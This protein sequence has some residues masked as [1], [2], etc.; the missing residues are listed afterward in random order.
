MRAIQSED[1]GRLLLA[2]AWV[3]AALLFCPSPCFAQGR[4]QRA[5]ATGSLSGTVLGA[6]E[7]PVSGARV[8]VQTSDGRTPRATTT[9]ENGRFRVKGLRSG[10]YDV[11]ARSGKVWSA[12]TR[13]V[14]VRENQEAKVKLRIPA[15][16]SAP[17]QT[18]RKPG[19]S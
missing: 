5:A 14:R 10:P 3:L 9:D 19:P 2:V 16:D 17:A 4:R 13:N 7:K 12:W 15:K 6:D 1:H 8:I 11:R 18:D